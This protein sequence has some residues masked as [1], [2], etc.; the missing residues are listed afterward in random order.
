MN[1]PA[2]RT[3]THGSSRPLALALAG[4]AL[5]ALASCDDFFGTED[6]KAKIKSD[7]Q[8]ATAEAVMVTLRAEKDSM[9]VPNPYGEQSFRVGVPQQITTT[10]GADYT[11]L[12]WTHTGAEG[13][14]VFEDASKATTKATVMVVKT[15]LQIVPMFTR[16]PYPISWDPYSGRDKII[17][18]KVIT[19]TFNKP[20]TL[21]ATDLAENGLIQV[22]TWSYKNNT[23][24]IHIET[25]LEL[26]VGGN[27][28]SISPK[29]TFK[30]DVF[31]SV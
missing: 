3:P 26:T 14:V 9:G 27:T 1:R 18:N 19:I 15:G 23:A 8:A 20:V 21:A 24:P 11:F 22:T 29:G 6:L 28:V 16:R 25:S 5:L 2:A 17:T 4:L 13:D 31:H 7:V 10:I 12:K 30:Y